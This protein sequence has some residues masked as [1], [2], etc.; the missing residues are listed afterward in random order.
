MR[1]IISCLLCLYTQSCTSLTKQEKKAIKDAEKVIEDVCDIEP[2]CKL[3]GCEGG[4]C[5]GGKGREKQ[6]VPLNIVG[7]FTPGSK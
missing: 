7:D 6:K 4:S 3:T 5:G 2:G 1:I